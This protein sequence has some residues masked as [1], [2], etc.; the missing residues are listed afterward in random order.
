MIKIKTNTRT[1]QH[2]LSSDKYDKGVKLS[3]ENITRID[4]EYADKKEGFLVDSEFSDFEIGNI[5]NNSVKIAEYVK[6]KRNGCK[7]KLVI[8]FDG[9][10]S[11]YT[12][13]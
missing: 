3:L 10:T 2:D 13:I 6:Y 5:I 1:F 8:W 7:Y 9:I 12:H 11:F 4:I